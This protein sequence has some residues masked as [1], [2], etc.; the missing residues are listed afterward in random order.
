MTPA[1]VSSSTSTDAPPGDDDGDA[2]TAAPGRRLGRSAR[3]VLRLLWPILLSVVVVSQLPRFREAAIELQAISVTRLV[4]GFVLVMS[5]IACYSG[6][7]AAALV[8]PDDRVTRRTVFRIQLSTRALANVAP[9]GNATAAALGFRLLT[10]SGVSGAGAGFALATAGF[11]S[12]VVL[13]GLFWLALAIALPTGEIDG[14]FL[15]VAVIGL[16]L[17]AGLASVLIVVGRSVDRLL[18]PMRRLARRRWLDPER[19]VRAGRQV[20][21]RLL[22]LRGDRAL[23]RRIIGWALMQW[24]LDMAALWVFLTAFDIDLD[25]LVLVVVFCAANIASAIP[26]TPGGLGIV[27][28]VYLT[29]LVQFG[30][31]FEAATF[32]VAAYRLVQY[33][34]PIVAGG[35]SY[36]GLRTGPWR[37]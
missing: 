3:T 32:A 22:V 14:P 13:N 10:R 7:T 9:G 11:G 30:F 26:I 20:R 25:P 16:V 28:G 6:L 5:S 4:L 1:S 15:V 21:H 18:G 35:V 2:T 37:I 27:E 36:L 34:F 23:L 17:L 33:V 8:A 31:T 24:T 12:A 29:S 19:V